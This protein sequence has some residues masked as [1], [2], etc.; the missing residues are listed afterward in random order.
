MSSLNQSTREG[1]AIALRLDKRKDTHLFTS[2]S[3]PISLSTPVADEAELSWGE[4]SQHS[5]PSDAWV[6]G[7]DVDPDEWPE[8][9][10]LV[11]ERS[12]HGRKITIRVLAPRKRGGA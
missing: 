8:W 4:I 3:A 5:W 7:A 11:A 9:T 1:D 2:Y 12:D 10:D 6:V